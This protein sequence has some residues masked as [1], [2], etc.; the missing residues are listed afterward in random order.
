MSPRCHR[1]PLR[2]SQL[3]A[4]WLTVK[5]ITR[6]SRSRE[7]ASRQTNSANWTYEAHANP[8]RSWRARTRPRQISLPTHPSTCSKR[9][10]TVLSHCQ[11]RQARLE[12]LLYPRLR[13]ITRSLV[14]VRDR[15]WYSVNSSKISWRR[16]LIALIRR[17]RQSR[18]LMKHRNA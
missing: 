11:K 18:R 8:C 16:P 5:R 13:S 12:Q 17:A 15:F 6:G 10:R 7:R 2:I 4:P 14:I 1:P 3:V 9:F